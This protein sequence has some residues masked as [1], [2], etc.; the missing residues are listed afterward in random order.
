MLKDFL[1]LFISAFHKTVKI[2]GQE[3]NLQLI[4]T[5]GQVRYY[6]Y[7]GESF[8]DDFPVILKLLNNG[9]CLGFF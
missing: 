1:C 9:D 2:G 7:T 3:Y 5:A 8:Q 6:N 4:D